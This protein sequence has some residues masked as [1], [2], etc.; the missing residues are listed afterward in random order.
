[1]KWR[2]RGKNR[3]A[4]KSGKSLCY[5]RLGGREEREI[6]FLKSTLCFSFVLPR[7]VFPVS[8]VFGSSSVLLTASNT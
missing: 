6:R 2:K 1:M 3:E 5:R 7:D 8:D 4:E